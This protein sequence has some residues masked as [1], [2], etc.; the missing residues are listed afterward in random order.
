MNS[1]IVRNNT[2]YT[3]TLLE[4]FEF[5]SMSSE[6]L[7]NSTIDDW[8]HSTEK[9]MWCKEHSIQP[10]IYAQPDYLHAV[11]RVGIFGY[12]TDKDST[13]FYLKWKSR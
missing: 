13:I 3:K 8:L 10:E 9:G 11:Q 1:K 2:V 7:I 6:Y 4:K 5:D 12:M